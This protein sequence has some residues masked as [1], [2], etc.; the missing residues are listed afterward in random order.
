[1]LKSD[2]DSRIFKIPAG[3]HGGKDGIVI[4]ERMVGAEKRVTLEDS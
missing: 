1:M 2:R 3:I 4:R